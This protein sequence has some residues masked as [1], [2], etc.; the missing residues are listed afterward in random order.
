MGEESK[1]EP[2]MSNCGIA[3]GRAIAT[4][5][6]N[7]DGSSSPSS[8]NNSGSSDACEFLGDNTAKAL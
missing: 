7:Q 1:L 2:R 4:T 3:M 6:Y 8:N 5:I